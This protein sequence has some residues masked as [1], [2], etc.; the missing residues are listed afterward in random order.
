MLPGLTYIEF[1]AMQWMIRSVGASAGAAIS[2]AVNIDQTKAGGVSGAIYIVFIVIQ[3]SS[4]LLSAFL[5][6]D[7][8]D[9]IRDDGTHLAIFKPP[10][11][12]QEMKALGKCFVDR[13]L[14]ILLPAMFVCEMALALVSTINGEHSK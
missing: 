12:K 8:K 6:I 4:L 3:C 11:F 7:P 2:F 14:L 1:L 9:V 10:Y 13:R 5:I